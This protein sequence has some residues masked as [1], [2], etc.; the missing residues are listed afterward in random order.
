MIYDYQDQEGWVSVW[1]GSCTDGQALE[2]YLSTVYLEDGED[3]EAY[4]LPENRERPCEEELRECFNGEFFNR[5]EYD[6][7]LT[8]DEDFRE[9]EVFPAATRDM[10]ELLDPF[11]DSIGFL[12]AVKA[13]SPA[14]LNALPACNTALVLYGF[15]YDGSITEA[16]RDGVRLRFLGAFPA[17]TSC[18]IV[19][20]ATKL[21]MPSLT[22]LPARMIWLW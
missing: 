9:A 21:P 10:A 6:F 5:F 4:F 20:S 18:L 15:R 8:F 17:S 2:Q 11:S 1:V 22:F 16:A 19:A 7:G 14:V 3:I 13:L 12:P